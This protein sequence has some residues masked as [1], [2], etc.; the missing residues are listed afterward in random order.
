MDLTRLQVFAHAATAGSFTKAAVMLGATQSAISRQISLFEK[1][2]GGRL[3]YRTGR[4]I[5]LTELG[6]R[7]LPRVQA[8]L[9]GARD[10]DNEIKGADSAPSGEV[11]LGVLAATASALLPPLQQRLAATCPAVF[12][13]IFEGSTGQL[14]EW[15]AAGHIDIGMTVRQGGSFAA[16][17][18][19]LTMSDSYLVGQAND[20][21]TREAT[22]DFTRLHRLPLILAGLPN[23]MR[24]SIEQLAH[25]KG[26]ELRVIMEANSLIAQICMAA[27]GCGYTILPLEA[28]AKGTFASKLGVSRI[29]NPS[30]RR[31]IALTSTTQR[32]LNLAGRV[33]FR[34]IRSIAEELTRDEVW[35]PVCP[36]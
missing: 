27:S 2:C 32:P 34:L 36:D 33:V 18:Q 14:D 17:D 11:R 15:I 21:I 19:P 25:Q 9:A 24:K 29:V 12:L 20:S 26:V 23:G 3:F 16:T 31:T 28:F 5:A 1:E 6:A 35:G 22:L 13:R 7:I 8:L 30:I 4:G 10:L